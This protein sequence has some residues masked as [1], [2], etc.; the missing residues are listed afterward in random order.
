L[1]VNTPATNV[2]SYTALREAAKRLL[3]YVSF[4]S[5]SDQN[6]AQASL[7]TITNPADTVES[8]IRD[9]I[10]GSSESV[11]S[12]AK[13]KKML[14]EEVAS[15]EKADPGIIFL[16]EGNGIIPI[17]ATKTNLPLLTKRNIAVVTHRAQS[18]VDFASSI[19]D[20]SALFCNIVPPVEMSL[21]VPYFD[22]RILYPGQ[23]SGLGK[24]NQLKFI[25]IGE[26]RGESFDAKITDDSERIG[27]DVAGME[28]FCMPQTLAGQYS[29]LNDPKL[30]QDRGLEVLDPIMPLLTLESANIQQVGVGGSLYA[31]TKID[32]KLI[33]H[34]RSRLS[35][36]E[37]LV[38]VEIFPTVTFRVEYGWAHPN[39]NEMTGGI[40]ANFL[41]KMRIRQ[42][43]SLYSVSVGTRDSTSLTVNISL[44]SKGDY[45]AKSANVITANSQYIPYSVVLSLIR[46]FVNVQVGK[47]DEN[48]TTPPFSPSKVGATI[49]ASTS[50]GLTT[51]KYVSVEAFYNLYAK[52]KEISK[53]TKDPDKTDESVLTE[54]KD[55]LTN[56]DIDGS[57][58]L[59]GDYL[60]N[61]FN[62]YPEGQEVDPTFG[63]NTTPFFLGAVNSTSADSG[64]S[65]YART[66]IDSIS[67]AAGL[68]PSEPGKRTS[69]SNVVPLACLVAKIVAKPIMIS[70]PTISEARIHFFS[71]NS[72]CGIMAE[73]SIGSF[74]IVVKDLL[75]R[76]EG[77]KKIS[78][79]NT[80]SSVASALNKMMAQVNDPSSRFYGFSQEIDALN[81]AIEEAQKTEIETEED[82]KAVQEAIDSARQ[83]NKTAV[84]NANRIYLAKGGD[85][86]AVKGTDVSFIPPRIK[87]Q[88]EVVPMYE[89]EVTE[90][91]K[92][93]LLRIIVYDDR[94][95]NFNKLGNLVSGMVNT[96]G[97]ALVD[98][99]PPELAGD[100]TKL[101]ENLKKA[102]GD[103]VDSYRIKDLKTMRE[104]VSKIYPT[105]TVG[106]EGSVIESATFNSQPSGDVASSYLL[107]AIGGETG[108]S[109]YGGTSESSAVDDV[110]VIP[111]NI[112]LNMIGNTC[113]AR[114]QTYYVD[115]G[116]GTTVDNTYAVQSVSHSIRP[117][118]FKTTVSM[119]PV[120][121]ATMRSVTRQV[122]ELIKMINVKEGEILSK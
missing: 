116:T 72:Q 47:E 77:D 51:N 112:T 88:M 81:K 70:D 24:L 108:G 33:L 4:S 85:V 68:I 12:S 99:A 6:S 121:S 16:N 48:K 95:G 13:L 50:D 60:K 38:S 90:S 23:I 61:I 86:R 75:E 26:K 19:S 91:V 25:G 118:S 103:E 83:V 45:I 82:R 56:L 40:Y 76:E 69:Y 87:Y 120:S 14:T 59:G 64:I 117:G 1:N 71:F 29:Q 106:I 46:Q 20:I 36:I 30:V 105:L 111:S 18:R 43:F 119:L 107:T 73:E 102:E 54:I 49:V 67:R 35:D 89:E 115:F 2:A 7:A 42:D 93:S 98:G 100:T 104:L 74:P 52:I 62:F 122:E 55:A 5:L 80:R 27:V 32:L 84:E 114:G 109:Q 113:M 66:Q 41:N 31:Q 3:N 10:L 17:D 37:P 63:A 39:T 65:T 57:E 101:L 44:I 97:I 110:L 58:T 53:G 96:N 15:V 9:Q 79:I 78:G 28:I 94:A 22:V 8:E 92:K 34:D 11:P 21:C